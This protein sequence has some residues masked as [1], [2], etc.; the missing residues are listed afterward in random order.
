[1]RVLL[2]RSS[3]DS[4]SLMLGRFLFVSMEIERVG[5]VIKMCGDKGERGKRRRFV[6]MSRCGE[7]DVN[8]IHIFLFCFVK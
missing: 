2:K 3:W 7:D 4:V 8:I 5:K 1:M 6:E